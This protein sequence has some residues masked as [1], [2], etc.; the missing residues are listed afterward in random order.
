MA[1]GD[2]SEYIVTM[3]FQYPAWDE[4]A[5]ITYRVSAR[6]KREANAKARRQAEND[7]HAGPWVKDKGRI[8]FSAVMAALA[9][10]R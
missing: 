8:T 4:K 6:S 2:F 7:G 9:E 5:G 1:Y 3:R 10:H